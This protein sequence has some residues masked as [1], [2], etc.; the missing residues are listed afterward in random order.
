LDI[1]LKEINNFIIDYDNPFK[2]YIVNDMTED[3]ID[4]ENINKRETDSLL[5]LMN[6]IDSSG[7]SKILIFLGEAGIG[8]THFL[9]RLRKKAFI[10]KIFNFVGITTIADISNIYKEILKGIIRTFK[11]TIVNERLFIENLIYEILCD[12]AIVLPKNNENKRILK[13][14]KK[15]QNKPEK[16]FD[17]KFPKI[18]KQLDEIIYLLKEKEPNFDTHT[19]KILFKILNPDSKWLCLDWLGGITLSESELKLLNIEYSIATDTEALPVLK[20]ISL[21]LRRPILLCIDQL[22]SIDEYFHEHRGIEKI[23]TVLM[24]LR[25]RFNKF[26]ILIMCQAHI[27]PLIIEKLSEAEKDRLDYITSFENPTK[28]DLYKII[29]LRLSFFYE[30]IKRI[31]PYPTYPFTKEYIS[32]AI[33]SGEQKTPR[34]TLRH[35]SALIDE[36]KKDRNVKEYFPPDYAEKIIEII[37]E[38]EIITKVVGTP[39]GSIEAIEIKLKDFILNERKNFFNNFDTEYANENPENYENNLKLSIHYILKKIEEQ[40]LKLFSLSIYDVDLV[41]KSKRSINIKYKIEIEDTEHEI[42]I[43]INNSNNANS[44][45]ATLRRLNTKLNIE[46]KYFSFYLRNNSLQIPDSWTK[47]N[48]YINSLKEMGDL[49]YI[50]KNSLQ[51][52]IFIKKFID[53]LS[54]GDLE[55][56]R[57]KLDNKGIILNLLEIFNDINVIKRITKRIETEIKKPIRDLGQEERQKPDEI[58]EEGKVEDNNLLKLKK[59][60]A[61]EIIVDENLISLD[62]LASKLEIEDDTCFKIVKSLEIDNKVIVSK[63]PADNDVIIMKKQ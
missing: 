13:F 39:V 26:G 6:E 29:E 34:S 27:W 5:D 7:N 50:D 40:K 19:L 36:I 31:P 44:V 32:Y 11:T 45:S 55:Y 2:N 22:E 60:K 1:S 56:P 30:N 3:I 4:V 53:K 54:A 43:E 51:N 59:I 21:L 63:N 12:L 35:F 24:D 37:E 18:E 42:F 62:K 16:F 47:V 46:K 33:G 15:V 8:K 49:I 52:F 17:I 9:S 41:M 57:D 23:F 10:T 25:D 58:T 14:L 20:T 61:Y 38:K 48:E 28:E